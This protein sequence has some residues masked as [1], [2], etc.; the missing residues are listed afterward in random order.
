MGA[1]LVNGVFFTFGS[2]LLS[3]FLISGFFRAIVVMYLMP[4]LIDLAVSYGKPSTHPK[5]N[6]NI[7]GKAIASKRGLYYRQQE[8]AESPVN[9]LPM[10]KDT[11]TVAGDVRY[12]QRRNW[13]KPETPAKVK[14]E[15][16]RP[17]QIVASRRAWFKDPEIL[18]AHAVRSPSPSLQ[19]LEKSVKKTRSREGLYYNDAGWAN[20]M[21]ETLQTLIR[22]NRERKAVADLKPVFVENRVSGVPGGI[23]THDLLLRRR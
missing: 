18:A 12:S 15:V 11:I 19:M 16:A 13:A 4:K 5:F 7:S 10:K 23:R 20:Y 2:R 3:V 14:K 8:L 6:L 1:F 9:T 17:V 21:K 22:E